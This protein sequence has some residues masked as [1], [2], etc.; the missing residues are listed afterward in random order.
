MNSAQAMRLSQ[1]YP[2]SS[3]LK[4]YE[5][6][7]L[8]IHMKEHFEMSIHLALVVSL[9]GSHLGCHGVVSKGHP[10]NG[11]ALRTQAVRTQPGRSQLVV[12]VGL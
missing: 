10:E 9:A 7:Q 12:A 8:N 11:Q 6:S 3:C 5:V 4:V 1:E 2:K